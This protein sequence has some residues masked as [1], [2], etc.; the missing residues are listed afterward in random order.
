VS[1]V[2]LLFPSTDE[3]KRRADELYRDGLAA[4]GEDAPTTEQLETLEVEEELGEPAVETKSLY[5][6]KKHGFHRP[7]NYDKIKDLPNGKQLWAG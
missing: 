6:F 2:T 7:E 1:I 5:G 4:S 3:E